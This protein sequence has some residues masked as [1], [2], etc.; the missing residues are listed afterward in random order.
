MD[1]SIDQTLAKE[2][3]KLAAHKQWIADQKKNALNN[4]LM[5]EQRI[6]ADESISDDEEED[7]DDSTPSL[8]SL[9][10]GLD[11]FQ[12]QN[13]D[14]PI[15]HS[16]QEYKE[17]LKELGYKS[18]SNKKKKR[19]KPVEDKLLAYG[20]ERKRKLQRQREME[21]EN[22]P[23]FKPRITEMARK[24]KRTE[25]IEER[26]REAEVNRLEKIRMKQE[27]NRQ[28]EPSYPFK[29]HLSRGTID[30]TSTRI[31]VSME[32]KTR[33]FVEE[34]DAKIQDLRARD[35]EKENQS[36]S[37]T[38][39]L[40][41]RTRKLM[42]TLKA[43]QQRRGRFED[44]IMHRNQENYGKFLKKAQHQFQETH[45]GTPKITSSAAQM[46][47]ET[48]ITERLYGMAQTL[49][50]KKKRRTAQQR[51]D[52]QA[53][54]GF[55]P[56]ISDS[57]SMTTTT[58]TNS[59]RQVPVYLD[60]LQRDEESKKRR[61]ER[62]ERLKEREKDM[63][64]PQ[65][66]Q[67]SKAIAAQLPP[68]RQRLLE[69]RK[70]HKKKPNDDSKQ[71]T[72]KPK[73]CARS[74]QI[75]DEK[76]TY[77]NN[78]ND[79][80]DHLYQREERR[81]QHI[82]HLRQFYQEKEMSECTF[83]PQ[84][85]NN[86]D[87][88]NLTFAERTERWA[89]KREKKL[90]RKRA[91]IE[92]KEM[93]KCTFKPNISDNKSVDP[94]MTNDDEYNDRNHVIGVSYTQEASYSDEDQQAAAAA[95]PLGFGEFVER[96]KQARAMRRTKREGVFVT[97]KNWKNR[98]TVPKAPKLGRQRG[99][100]IKSLQRPFSPSYQR[101]QDGLQIPSTK[102]KRKRYGTPERK[103]PIS[104][105]PMVDARPTSTKRSRSTKKRRFSTPYRPVTSSPMD[106]DDE[107]EAIPRRGLFSSRSS[108]KILDGLNFDYDDPTIIHSPHSPR[109]PPPQDVP[110]SYFQARE[111]L[112][113]MSTPYRKSEEYKAR[114]R[115]RD[116]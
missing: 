22:D 63:H 34:R 48:S 93:E 21:R 80:I 40:S 77:S 88:N 114:K 102:K 94:Y 54:Y 8:Q 86:I 111:I 44:N 55:E 90:A 67:V 30:M 104:P 3:E 4:S 112:N 42:N 24:Q 1:V 74:K 70:V 79:R 32:E 37:D 64:H 87:Q 78:G 72:F 84:T 71:C 18:K 7:D 28:A 31:D 20:E 107:P 35:Q 76:K 25:M 9:S 47:R 101:D 59:A 83:A 6:D 29:P 17:M 108:L 39:K 26:L 106:D 73:L 19:R 60:L 41:K 45:T 16:I 11:N 56:Q 81:Q 115:E 85:K 105:S 96:Q 14:E 61:M 12:F 38:P 65:I 51:M 10:E 68:S 110:Q 89:M 113:N 49:S 57:V 27:E 50:D 100:R 5:I 62:L 46:V 58:S 103:R 82:Q 98:V 97:G 43:K 109:S 69:K 13:P 2:R 52:E 53:E 23:E 91:N 36:M 116:E 75:D 15:H 33:R 66:N 95:D 99:E 92:R